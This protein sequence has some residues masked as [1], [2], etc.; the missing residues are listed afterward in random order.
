[1]LTDEKIT[2]LWDGHTVPAFGKT[3]INPIVF[4]RAVEAEVRAEYAALTQKSVELQAKPRPA[5]GACL[6]RHGDPV[7]SHA[8]G[9]AIAECEDHLFDQVHEWLLQQGEAGGT[10][11]EIAEGTGIERVTVSPRLKPMEKLGL[12]RRTDERRTG[13]SGRSSIVWIGLKKI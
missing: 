4:A 5:L 6:A 13:P 12:V 3:G 1:M 9:V 10:S 2:S 11:F 8:A 7:T